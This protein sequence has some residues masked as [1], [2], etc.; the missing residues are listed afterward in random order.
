MVYSQHLLSVSMLI[1]FIFCS[2]GLLKYNQYPAKVFVGDT[3]CYFAGIV[4]AMAG[5]L[6]HYSKTM[7][8]FFLPQLA[9]FL[10]SLP[11]ITG[12]VKCPRHR[13]PRYDPR[14]DVL[15]AETSNFTLINFTLW[16]FGPMNEESLC[17]L[18]CVAQLISCLFGF[19]VRY[20][21]VQVFY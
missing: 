11:Q 20:S 18:L 10:I 6:G 4:L 15:E 19:W 9:N 21:L 8:L 2:L 17:E 3:Y 13:L 7:L 16:L 14:S 1:P 5:I 12:I